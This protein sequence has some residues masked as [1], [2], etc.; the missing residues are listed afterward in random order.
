MSI[1]IKYKKMENNNENN[2]FQKIKN[3]IYSI[4]WDLPFENY[5]KYY[6]TGIIQKMTQEEKINFFF[7]RNK[8]NIKKNYATRMFILRPNILDD[9]DKIRYLENKQKSDRLKLIYLATM[10]VNNFGSCYFFLLNKK[11]SSVKY[12]VVSNAVMILAFPFLNKNTQ[13]LNEELYLKYRDVI[14]ED[15]VY[16]S[17][18][19][20][21]NI[22]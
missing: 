22:D 7:E 4:I 15:K 9:E 13:R 17:I 3:I 14:N 8:Q 12:M 6:K 2:F 1:V 21:S 20:A 19:E 11:M 16:S 18:K 10:I 5:H